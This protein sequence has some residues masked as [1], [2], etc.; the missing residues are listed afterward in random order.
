[1]DRSLHGRTVVVTGACSDIGHEMAR[2]F[3]AAGA[4]V[5]AAD[6]V[7]AGVPDG[8]S[9]LHLNTNVPDSVAVALA[10]VIARTGRLDVLCNNGDVTARGVFLGMRYALPA[11]LAR[12]SGVIV[13]TVSD[14]A[15]CGGAGEGAI[16]AFTRQADDCY[17]NLGVRSHS[18]V[19]STAGHRSP[20]DLA[21]AALALVAAALWPAAG[22]GHLA[23]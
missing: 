17:A 5:Y 20:A 11:M 2:R 7:P 12:R 16:V 3:H 1:M 18:L 19:H 22:D 13:N 15:R 23:A 21:R 6:L 14:H 10:R 8:T 9:A 4:R